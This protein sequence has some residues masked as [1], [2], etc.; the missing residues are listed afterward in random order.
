MYS[1][2][3]VEEWLRSRRTAPPRGSMV[4]KT[5]IAVGIQISTDIE[6]RR[7]CPHRIGRASD[8]GIPPPNAVS[9]CPRERAAKKRA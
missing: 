8:G 9:H 6:N 2:L 3:N 4:D 1:A 5:S 7:D